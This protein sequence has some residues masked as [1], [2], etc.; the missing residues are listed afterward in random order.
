MKICGIEFDKNEF[1]A[2]DESSLYTVCPKS[3]ALTISI[4]HF[5]SG[6]AI[7][8][9]HVVVEDDER[10]VY[11]EQLTDVTLEAALLKCFPAI[12][13]YTAKLHA[14]ATLIKKQFLGF[15]QE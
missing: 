3:S 5:H 11:S 14:H 10:I 15:I 9:V 4:V 12:H 13:D 8:E 6:P 2:R 1:W 7:G